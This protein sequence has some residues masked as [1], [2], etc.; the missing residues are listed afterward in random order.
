MSNALH[1]RV[2]F[3]RVCRKCGQRL[4]YKESENAILCP[5]CGWMYMQHGK[6]VESPLA[7]GREMDECK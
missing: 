7:I 2:K 5:E 6:R 3:R 1:K 4:V